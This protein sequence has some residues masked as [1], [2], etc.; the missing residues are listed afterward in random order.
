MSFQFSEMKMTSLFTL[1]GSIIVGTTLLSSHA[2]AASHEDSNGQTV[3]FMGNSFTYGAGSAVQY[4]RPEL[5][6][7]LNGNEKGGVPS[8]FKAFT[9][10]AG[11]KF[12]VSHE[13]IGGSGIDRHLA[14]KSDV[15]AKAWDHVVMHG[16]STLDR[17][18]P[19]DPRALVKSA[20]KMAELLHKQNA[21]VNIRLKSTWSRADQTYPKKGHWYGKTI[22]VMAKDVRAGYDLAASSTPHIAGVIPVGEAW[23][24]AIATG[25]A[26]AN[27]YDG[28]GYGQVDLWANDHYH[29]GTY[30]Y[31]LSALMVFG[32]LTGHDPRSLGEGERCAFEL[33]VS[34][35]Q[36]AALQ[37]VAFDE[38]SSSNSA[39][40]LKRFERL[41]LPR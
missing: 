35:S 1:L 21:K 10:Q 4:Y 19:G 20:K 7:D 3:L 41:P 34:K 32:E 8:L 36:A 24:R 40:V 18:K 23:N 17:N 13:L 39:K 15:V 37:Q 6:T 26:D 2:V 16:Y 14:E 27:P 31:Y 33:G 28:I 29:G 12:D 38:L 25:V 30:G 5:V 11:L 9:V 22:D